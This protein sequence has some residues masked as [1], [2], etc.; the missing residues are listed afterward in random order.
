MQPEIVKRR[1]AEA[2]E[3]G[4]SLAKTPCGNFRV[5][6]ALCDLYNFCNCDQSCCVD[7]LRGSERIPMTAEDYLQVPVLAAHFVG[8]RKPGFDVCYSAFER[9]ERAASFFGVSLLVVCVCVYVGGWVGVC[10][11]VCVW[12]GGWMGG[13]V[14][15]CVRVCVCVRE[16]E[17]RRGRDGDFL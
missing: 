15:G 7:P 17:R 10:V 13:W 9:G 1:R 8:H 2:R 5:A 11:G 16:R 14:G 12:G 3:Q 6:F 4:L